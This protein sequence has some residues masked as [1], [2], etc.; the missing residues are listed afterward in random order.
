MSLCLVCRGDEFVEKTFVLD[1]KF[2]NYN[3]AYN[4]ETDTYFVNIRTLYADGTETKTT[5]EYNRTKLNSILTKLSNMDTN[6]NSIY[7]LMQTLRVNPNRF[8]YYGANPLD[9]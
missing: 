2:I 7:N 4:P 5:K 8:Y 1:N 6:S 9:L 3:G